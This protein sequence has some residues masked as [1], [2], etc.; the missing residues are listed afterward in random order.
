GGADGADRRAALFAR[1]LR[2]LRGEGD[3]SCLAA[4]TVMGTRAE[5]GSITSRSALSLARA[6]RAGELS[7]SEVVEA[8]I[9]CHQ[10]LAPRI[11]ALA[12][13]RFDLARREATLA[14]E[15]LRSAGPAEVLQ[16]LL[17]AG[18]IPLGLTNTSE[19]TLW[20]ESSNR[21]YGRTNNPYDPTRTAGG[22]SGGEGAAVGSGA[23]PFG[24][25]SDIA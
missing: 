14:D 4:L 21:L 1:A 2:A 10:R 11:N 17:D 24:L 22:S 19:L 23:S 20:I 5:S 8:H 6:I 13:D 12:A 9:E 18:A 7:A 16:R 15:L 3:E 25:A